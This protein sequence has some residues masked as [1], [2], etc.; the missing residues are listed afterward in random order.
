MPDNMI[1]YIE[2]SKGSTQK[3]KELIIKF[4][5]VVECKIKIETLRNKPY[6]EGKRLIC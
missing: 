5:S 4:S 6:Q 3:L 1:P 2:N